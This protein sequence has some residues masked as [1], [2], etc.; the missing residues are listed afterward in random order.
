MGAAA[1]LAG[2]GGE[3]DAINGEHLAA[4]EAQAV[5]SEQHLGEER[6]DLVG[7]LAHEF[8]DVGVAG[9]AVA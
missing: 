8:G 2:V 1:F 6:L 9:L 7:Q 4:D 3:L 5:A